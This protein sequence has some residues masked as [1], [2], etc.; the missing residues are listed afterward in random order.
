MKAKS[1]NMYLIVVLLVTAIVP[2]MVSAAAALPDYKPVD[3]GPELRTWEPTQERI[4][5]R[6][7]AETAAVAAAV[8]APEDYPCYVETKEWMSLDD[9]EGYYFFT[10]Y[11]LIAETATSE[12]WVQ[13]DLSYQKVIR[14]T[15]P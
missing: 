13:A 6:A 11:Y 9:Y 3:V 2:A 4:A 15:H 1:F 5:P 14:A 12:L 10:D 7:D 8:S